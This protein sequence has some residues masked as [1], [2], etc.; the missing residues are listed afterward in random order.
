MLA[1]LLVAVAAATAPVPVVPVA[2]PLDVTTLVDDIGEDDDAVLAARRSPRR[3]TRRP[4]TTRPKAVRTASPL[5]IGLAG[6]GGAAIGAAVGIAGVATS[7]AF[8]IGTFGEQPT[9]VVVVTAA[10]AI[11]IAVA[12]PFLAGLGGGLGVLLADPR[13]TATDWGGLASCA[14]TGVC[15]GCS[16]IFGAVTGGGISTSGCGN[17]APDKP[18]EWTAAAAAAGI[19]VG[20]GL[21]AAAGFVLAPDR[22]QLLAPI[23]IGAFAGGLVSTAVFAGLAGGLGA[24]MR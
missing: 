11:G 16:T 24:T 17:L 3:S 1:A 20:G 9:E 19:I 23:G 10:V 18:A 14:S 5:N 8:A 12:T 6:A 22:S 15:T 7:G 21:G 4:S 13:T 2:G